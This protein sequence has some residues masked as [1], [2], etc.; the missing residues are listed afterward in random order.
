MFER[1]TER[2]K[3]VLFFA[4][5]EASQL[6]SRTTETEHLL[7][8]LIREGKG[9]ACGTLERSGVSLDSQGK[10]VAE[11]VRNH[12]TPNHA[13]EIPFSAEMKRVLAFAD[14]ESRSLQ[15]EH[16]GT[17]HLLLGVLRVEQS[18]G[19]RVLASV[20]L[21]LLEAQDIAG[22]TAQMGLEG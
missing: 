8:G 19:G 10:V 14:E 13:I 9:G 3:R 18:A 7:L 20:G 17:E 16:I 4:R 15:H 22:Q 6:G 1:Y 12:G 21:A 2:A 5:Y 11:R